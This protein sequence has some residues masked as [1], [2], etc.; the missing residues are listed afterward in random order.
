MSGMKRNLKYWLGNQEKQVLFMLGYIV[1]M[2]GVISFME[3]G[4]IWEIFLQMLPQYM[5]MIMLVFSFVNAFNCINIYF[6]LTIS[7]GGSRK[8][9]FIAMQIAQHLMMLEF[10]A[11]Y[12]ASLLPGLRANS[13]LSSWAVAAM[14]LTITFLLQG[15]GSVIAIVCVKFGKGVGVAIY[16]IMIIV[17]VIGVGAGIGLTAMGLFPVQGFLR[18]LASGFWLLLPGAGFDVLMAWLLYRVIRCKDLQFA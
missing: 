9:S 15:I 5:L 8:T 4:D 17:V 14:G 3:G 2:A 12:L 13:E 16:V 11:A 18:K 1:V 6:P 7:L 10:L